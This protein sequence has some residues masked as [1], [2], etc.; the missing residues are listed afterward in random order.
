[1]L[2]ADCLPLQRRQ[3]FVYVPVDTDFSEDGLE[4]A[5]G[6]D[7]EGT[8][9]DPPVLFSIHILQLVDSVLL[10]DRRI[11]IADQWE[12]QLILGDEFTMGFR[13]VQ[14]DARTTSAE[15]AR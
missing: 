2:L 13:P 4:S 1:M 15:Q 14:A 5:L 9:F 3:Y 12:G 6:I 11:F 8:A 7:D 10:G